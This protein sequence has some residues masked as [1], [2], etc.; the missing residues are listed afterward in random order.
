MVQEKENTCF[1][2][3]VEPFF[4]A[5]CGKQAKFYINYDKHFVNMKLPLL[6]KHMNLIKSR[7]NSYFLK[8]L[9]TAG[10]SFCLSYALN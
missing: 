4:V 10:H 5:F 8:I 6:R 9:Q 7:K 2:L 3:N 1:K